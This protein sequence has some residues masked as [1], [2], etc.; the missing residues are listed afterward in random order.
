VNIGFDP[1]YDVT[2]PQI[3][4]VAGIERVEAL[5]DTGAS[6][7]CIDNLLAA[8]I[9][10]PIVDRQPIGGAG[11]QHIANVYLERII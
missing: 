1:N 5:V 4:A 3:L 7:S 2:K 11:G 6:V 9:N 10:L 8:Q